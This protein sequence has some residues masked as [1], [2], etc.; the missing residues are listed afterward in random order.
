MRSHSATEAA[1]ALY[2]THR[3]GLDEYL[4]VFSPVPAQLGALFTLNGRV[5]GLDHFDS[6]RTL[7]TLLPKL[8]ESSAL[9]AIDRGGT[10]TGEGA[11]DDARRFLDAVAKSD[12]E[13]FEAIGLGEDLR[14][15]DSQIAGGALL[16][17]GRVVHLC[18]FRLNA[19]ESAES[20][21][22]GSRIA[23]ASQRR[24]GR[25]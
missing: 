24:R 8:V 1:A 9:D 15:R 7:S 22:S 5:L 17:G 12:T 20:G 23:R 25:L 10:E 14:L 6:H 18:A 19:R 13:R 16:S 4:R 11:R 3:A 2:D 21:V